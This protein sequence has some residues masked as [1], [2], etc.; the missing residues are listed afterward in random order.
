MG[1]ADTVTKAYMRR[2]NIFADAFNYFIYNGESVVNPEQ[3]TE[4]DTTEL[5]LPFGS[6]DK[7]K[8]QPD[9]LVQKYRDILKSAVIMQEEEATYVLLGIENQ[10][11]IHYA[12]PVRN[13]IYDALQYGKQVAD[14]AQRH[15]SR[16]RNTEEHTR[17]HS[18][19]EFLSGFYNGDLLKPVITLVIHFG[20]EEWD[21]PLSLHEMMGVKDK[22]L[23]GFVQNY[24]IHL[25]D[26]AKIIDEEFRK[27]SSSLREVMEYIK[28]SKDKNKLSELLKDNPRMVIERDAAMVIKAITNTPIE[29][30]EEMEEID[31]CKAIDSLM[32]ESREQGIEQG[33]EIGERR[34]L[35]QLVKEGDL[36]L[37]RAAA[38]AGMTVEQFEKDME[39][40]SAVENIV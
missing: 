9:D 35:V 29:I 13:M 24:Q 11:N 3:L 23:L 39:N 21:A 38:K 36:K 5:A 33:M 31:M 26:P 4:V 18:K 6:Q 22:K 2:N 7:G 32:T 12:M 28:Y 15:R 10:T 1:V 8:E 14:T 17:A 19:S 30:E 20:A 37:E 34:M 25:I 40:I 27:F 16:V